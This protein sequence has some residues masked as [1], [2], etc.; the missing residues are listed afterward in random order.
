MR[1]FRTVIRWSLFTVSMFF[2]I[3]PAGC[4]VN[5]PEP[6]LAEQRDNFDGTVEFSP[7]KVT[8]FTLRGT[9]PHIGDYTARGEATFHPGEAE[10]SLVGEGAAV[11]E[12]PE[13]DLLVGVVTWDVT[14]EQDGERP[15]E[16]RFSWRDSVRFSDGSTVESTGRFA[17]AEDRP[18]GL[19]VIAI[20]AI[21]IGMLL[22][23]IQK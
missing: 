14:A 6:Q 18:P 1:R 4:G 22:P 21:L 2:Q 15:S 8:P 20:I 5:T 9:E 13:G 23:A 19:V 17:E 10:G 16:I 3:V 12:T 11:F 7:D